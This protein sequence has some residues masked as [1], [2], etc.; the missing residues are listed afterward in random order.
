MLVGKCFTNNYIYDWLNWNSLTF[1]VLDEYGNIAKFQI[2]DFWKLLN[3]FLYI[4]DSLKANK[5][6]NVS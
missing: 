4:N 3:S 1:N 6:I 5:D 2:K